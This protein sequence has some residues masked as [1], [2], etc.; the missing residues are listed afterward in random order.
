[1]PGKTHYLPY[2]VHPETCVAGISFKDIT[3]RLKIS[4]SSK[5]APLQEALNIV[6]SLE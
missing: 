1:V 3:A 5:Y 4:E 6:L 2:T